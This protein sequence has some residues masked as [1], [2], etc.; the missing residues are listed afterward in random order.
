MSQCGSERSSAVAIRRQRRACRSAPRALL[1]VL[2]S[3]VWLLLGAAVSSAATGP[4]APPRTERA[5][6]PLLNRFLAGPMR[7]VDEI[8]FAVRVSMG[9]HWYENFAYYAH[10][11]DRRAYGDGG[12][13]CRL[14]LRTG[15]LKVLLEDAKGG[16]RDPQVHYD[17]QKILFSY[18]KADS[19]YF[20][21]HEIDVD[22][23]ILA[24]ELGA[25]GTDRLL[26]AG[27]LD[28]TS[29]QDTLALVSFDA[30]PV[31]GPFTIVEVSAGSLGTAAFDKVTLDG[32]AVNPSGFSFGSVP[33]RVAYND[34]PG[35]GGNIQVLAVPEP[36]SVR[37]LLAAF[38]TAAVAV[39]L[40]C[41]RRQ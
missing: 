2:L 40:R 17:G 9:S 8:L 18:R 20:H 12:R 25:S 6:G 26:I 16:I 11:P 21:L 41:G 1:S 15:E 36:A 23:G 24:I 39:G 3:A 34:Y 4:G 7:G 27:T 35:G 30:P 37:L 5:P 38:A 32:A 29:T 31:G 28:L 22:G 10:E 33:Y 13:L 19:R 14:N